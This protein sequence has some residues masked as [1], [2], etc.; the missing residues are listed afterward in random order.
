M[1]EHRLQNDG[2]FKTEED[3]KSFIYNYLKLF[4]YKNENEKKQ[5]IEESFNSELLKIEK[6]EFYCLELDKEKLSEFYK[7]ISPVLDKE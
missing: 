4:E 2:L 1:K 6:R 7:S 5:I 3:A